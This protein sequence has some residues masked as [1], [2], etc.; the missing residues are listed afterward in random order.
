MVKVT[1]QLDGWFDAD[2]WS[3]S[4]Q[5]LERLQTAHPGEYPGILLLTVQR[6]VK[7]WRTEKATAMMF[8][9]LGATDSTEGAE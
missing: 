9:D 3:T 4:R 2:P 6:R 1:E 7:I 8:G 5:L